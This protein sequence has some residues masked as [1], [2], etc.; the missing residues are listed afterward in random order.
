M[1][2]NP[3]TNKI[4]VPNTSSAD[5]TVIT[6]QQV[7]AISLTTTI[8]P[9]P[10]NLTINPVPVFT[11]TTSSSY[12]PTVP[13]VQSVY[14][15]VDTWQGPWLQASGSAPT[16]TGQ[17]PILQLGTHILYAYATDAQQGDSVQPG[18]ASSGRAA[19]S[20]ARSPLMRSQLCARL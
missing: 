1:A 13:L 7:N 16:F 14:Y 2:V 8:T 15:Q 4:Y 10:N 11:F 5:V 9:R 20:L 18:S 19:R 6:E 17:L 3:A 12:A